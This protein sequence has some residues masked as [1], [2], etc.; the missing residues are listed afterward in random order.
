MSRT[1]KFMALILAIAAVL[2]LSGCASAE[3][4]N[5]ANY[6]RYSGY[7]FDAFDTT[8]TIL[9]YCASPEEFEKLNQEA[10]A[11]LMRFHKL[12]DIYNSYSGITNLHDVNLKAGKEPVEVPQEIIDILKYAKEWNKLTKG[13]MNVAFGSV[14]RIWHDIRDY[15]NTFPDDPVLPS[16]P[17]LE[18]ASKHCRIDDLIIDEENRTVFFA[19]PELQLD[20]GAVAKGYSVEC[21]A[22]MLMGEG[23]NNL[24]INAG[25]NVRAVGSK[26]T[27]EDWVVGVSNP[28]TS[29]AAEYVAKTAVSDKAVITSGVYQRFFMFD[30]KR[31]HHIIDRDSL[32]PEERFLSVTIITDDSGY[33]DALSTAVFNMDF[34]EGM[35]FV[36]SLENVEA[37]WILPD[38]TQKYSSG[39][40]DY[41]RD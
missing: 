30:G 40:R 38:G 19:D 33:G 36:S 29:S 21:V 12:F 18:A 39:F 15:N 13:S 14:L 26:I 5:A 24:L 35:E 17:D 41:L 37:M 27:G 10:E 11:E 25:G 4:K 20:V 31:Y 34:D 3:K 1:R 28:D 7:I 9:A 32:E 23:F 6:E 22:K 8:T 2:S 16:R